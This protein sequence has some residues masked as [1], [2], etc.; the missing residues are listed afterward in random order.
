ME[1]YGKIRLIS[2][3]ENLRDLSQQIYSLWASRM[4]STKIGLELIVDEMRSSIDPT[5][6]T[7]SEPSDCILYGYVMGVDYARGKLYSQI[8]DCEADLYGII[9]DMVSKENA[10][11]E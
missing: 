10:N 9:R 8:N 5:Y 4:D 2:S 6:L 3:V 1:N 11:D 7:L